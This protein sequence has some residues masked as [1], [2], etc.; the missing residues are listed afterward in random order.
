MATFTVTFELDDT[1]D[2]ENETEIR[3]QIGFLGVLRIEIDTT[4]LNRPV[5]GIIEDALYKRSY[6]VTAGELKHNGKQ[7]GTYW[8]E[9]A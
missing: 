9:E 1:D 2:H 5:D 3:E 4:L 6:G 8:T 7:I